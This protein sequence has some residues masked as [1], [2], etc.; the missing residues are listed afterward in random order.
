VKRPRLVPF[1]KELLLGAGRTL[2]PIGDRVSG[3]RCGQRSEVSG[4]RAGQAG[5]LLDTPVCQRR[6]LAVAIAESERIGGDGLHVQVHGLGDA[7]FGTAA[8]RASC[9]KERWNAGMPLVR[10][11]ASPLAMSGVRSDSRYTLSVHDG[12][13]L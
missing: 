4:R 7:R 12:A 13:P 2:Q 1:R 11:P 5:E 8:P 3:D 10:W 6:R 9:L